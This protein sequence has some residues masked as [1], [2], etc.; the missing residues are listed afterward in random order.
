MRRGKP[1]PKA[2]PDTAPA[3]PLFDWFEADRQNRAKLRTAGYSDGRITN[4]KSRG[5]PLAELGRVAHLM[6]IAYDEY[7]ALAD[8]SLP[9]LDGPVSPNIEEA[10]AIRRLRK[11]LPAYRSYVLSLALMENHEKQRLF[12]DIMQE[13]IPNKTVERA[14]GDAPH[15]AAQKR[16]KQS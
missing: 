9:K 15:V 6:G 12:L 10:H 16:S 1:K 3:E 7:L 13:H 14:Y 2:K 4:W 8:V 5:V 11:A